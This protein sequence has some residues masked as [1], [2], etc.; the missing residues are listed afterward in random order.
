[1]RTHQI[2]GRHEL[3]R[4]L[5]NKWPVCTRY[6]PN[7]PLHYFCHSSPIFMKVILDIRDNKAQFVMELLNSLS[8]VKVSPLTPYKAEVLGGVR[9]AVEELNAIRSG[10]LEAIP[11]KD[12]LNGL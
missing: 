4:S 1:M 6:F 3:S 9:E 7:L 11:A 12:L 2:R 8:F 10:K 5:P